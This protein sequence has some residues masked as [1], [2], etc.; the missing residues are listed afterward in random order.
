MNL[1]KQES[2]LAAFQLWDLM[3]NVVRRNKMSSDGCLHGEEEAM[4]LTTDPHV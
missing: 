2:V 4:L 1:I 3:R